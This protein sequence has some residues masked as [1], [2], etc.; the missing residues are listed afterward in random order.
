MPPVELIV[1][2]QARIPHDQEL[3]EILSQLRTAS[4][5]EQ[6]CLDY[7][8]AQGQSSVGRFFLLECWVDTE[9]LARHGQTPH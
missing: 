9:A 2:L 7:R 6:G 8:M 1:T 5:Q 4:L 3:R